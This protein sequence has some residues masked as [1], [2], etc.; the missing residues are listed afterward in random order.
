MRGP[1]PGARWVEPEDFHITLRFAGDIDNRAADEFAGF[2]DE[3][4]VVP[5]DIRDFRHRLFG[6]RTPRVIW[7]GVEGGEAL[8]NLQ[9]AH[10]RAARRAGLEPD[11]QTFRPHVT[12]A[13]LRGTR[14]DAVARFLRLPW[15]AQVG[16][17]QG[18]ALCA[19]L[20]PAR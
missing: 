4:E 9:R 16:A 14:P 5:F 3:I 11:P 7:A 17:I 10:E 8:A 12:L 6:G 2:L 18:R 13:R 1:L 15:R 19:V 20:G